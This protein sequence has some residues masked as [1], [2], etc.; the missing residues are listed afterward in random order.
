MELKVR[1]NRG[2]WY[3]V[4]DGATEFDAVIEIDEIT[5]DAYIEVTNMYRR[6]SDA[7]EAQVHGT[8]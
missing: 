4:H 8:R 6:M 3:A 1:S 5:G 2:E 7:I